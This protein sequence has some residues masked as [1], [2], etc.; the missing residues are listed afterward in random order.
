MYGTRPSLRQR[1]KTTASG[2]SSRRD[3]I[4]P[5]RM[6]C[7][8]LDIE[9][10]H[11]R[12]SDLDTL[13]VVA[14]IKLASHRQPSLGRCGRN[15]LDHRFAADQRS[16]SPGLGNMAEQPMLD[17]VPLRG[18]R[19]I[20]AYLKRQA[21]FVSQ[22]LQLNLEQAHAGTIRTTAIRR[23]HQLVHVGI[24]LAAHDIQP[25]SDRI[26]RELCGVVADAKIY[27]SSIGGDVVNS[28]R[29]DFP[30]LLVNEI[31]HVD[32]VGAAFRAVIAAAIFVRTTWFLLLCVDRNHR[33]T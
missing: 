31:V 20:M 12:V 21:G 22:V 2:W 19:W 14:C 30:K 5:L 10:Y 1:A 25:A 6:E 9:G 32:F 26:N 24:A 29:G 8:T 15:Q 16:S 28:I 4:I 7:V 23:D 27:A 18:S 17:L 33:L 11:L 13:R 3:R